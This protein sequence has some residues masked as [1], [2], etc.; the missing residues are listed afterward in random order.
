LGKKKKKTSRRRYKT[1]EIVLHILSDYHGLNLD[2]NNNRNNRQPTYSWKLNNTL[3]NNQLVRE[4]I[5][6]ELKTFWN[7][8]KMET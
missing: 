1:T 3:L 6:K 2:F 4:E 8:M 7:S 5:K